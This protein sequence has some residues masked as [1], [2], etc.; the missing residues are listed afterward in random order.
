MPAISQAL[1][2][3]PIYY[4]DTDGEPIAESDPQRHSLIYLVEALRDHFQ[5]QTEVYA[6]GNLLIY[7][8]E[9]NPKRSVAPDVF[10]VF[11]VPNQDRDIYQTWVEG[12]GPDVVI[13]I[14]SRTTRHIDEKVKP[15]LYQQLGVQEYFQYDPKGHYLKPALR[16]RRL[17]EEGHYELM[18]S[19][20][21]LDGS[22]WLTSNLLGLQLRLEGGR[23]RLFDPQTGD[24]LD[25]YSEAV[26]GRRQAE[27]QAATERQWKEEAVKGY[28]QAERQAAAE[29]QLKELAQQQQELA[30]QQARQALQQLERERQEKELLAQQ[31]RA[32]GIN[33]EEFLKKLNQP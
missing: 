8:E 31:L 33:P 19:V 16:G 12:K 30:Q 29:R 21:G 2:L 14:T 32:L 18:N 25:T 28:R 17:T 22:V 24:Y 27:R 13:E 7:Y 3:E 10:V 5:P 9:G 1:V 15:T 23:L 11:G 6:S 4:P 26:K 20:R